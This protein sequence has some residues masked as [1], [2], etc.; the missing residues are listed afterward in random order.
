MIASV[1]VLSKVCILDLGIVSLQCPQNMFQKENDGGTSL[2]ARLEDVHKRLS[3]EL[4]I[5]APHYHA[6]VP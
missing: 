1:T 6:D 5:D 4:S 3:L 2:I